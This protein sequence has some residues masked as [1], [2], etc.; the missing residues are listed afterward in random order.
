MMASLLDRSSLKHPVASYRQ[1]HTPAIPALSVRRRIRGPNT[2]LN[3][4]MSSLVRLRTA[5]ATYA[6]EQGQRFT[7]AYSCSIGDLANLQQS[8][9]DQRWRESLGAWCWST[10][11]RQTHTAEEIATMAI[12]P[13]QELE[14]WYARLPSPPAAPTVAEIHQRYGYDPQTCTDGFTRRQLA[15]SLAIPEHITRQYLSGGCASMAYA[16]GT[17]LDLDVGMIK[18]TRIAANGG[19]IPTGDVI[20]CYAIASDANPADPLI[21]DIKGLRPYSI[22][23]QDFASLLAMVTRPDDQAIELEPLLLDAP[24]DLFTLHGFNPAGAPLAFSDARTHMADYFNGLKMPLS[25]DRAAEK[26]AIAFLEDDPECTF[27][28]YSDEPS[29]SFLF[30][31]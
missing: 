15:Q 3:R 31:H 13:A 9:I 28:G 18:A 14:N 4:H 26:D 24:H 21:V 22:M 10:A 5:L 27:T 29:E 30:I 1:I 12:P 19:R 23:C 6:P 17:L 16:L 2:S 20:H 8:L 7:R 25:A 11:Q